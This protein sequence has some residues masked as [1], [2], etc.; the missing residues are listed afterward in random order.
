[1]SWISE[2]TDW[3]TQIVP[4]DLREAAIAEAKQMIAAAQ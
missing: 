2:A 3:K 4:D 1:M